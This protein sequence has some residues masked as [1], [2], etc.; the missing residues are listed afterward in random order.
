MIWMVFDKKLL[1]DIMGKYQIS[2]DVVPLSVD[3]IAVAVGKWVVFERAEKR[4]PDTGVMSVI[5]DNV[6]DLRAE[7]T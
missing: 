5:A 7:L 4:P 2:G 6:E 1:A 3:R